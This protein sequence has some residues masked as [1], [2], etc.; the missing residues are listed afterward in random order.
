VTQ[1]GIELA[2][3]RFV[4]QYLNHLRHRVPQCYSYISVP[5]IWSFG[6]YR[7]SFTFAF[8]GFQNALFLN[9]VIGSLLLEFDQFLLIYVLLTYQ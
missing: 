3:F 9:L 5:P 2:T 7:D 1:S 6:V 8:C 4:A